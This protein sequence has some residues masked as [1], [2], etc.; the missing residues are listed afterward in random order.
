MKDSGQPQTTRSGC[1]GSRGRYSL[2]SPPPAAHIS[3]K[4]EMVGMQYGWVEIISPE[5][6]WGPTWSHCYVLTRCKGCGSVQW[7]FLENLTSGK[8]KG[9][10]E[11]SKPRQIPKWLEK[12]LSGAKQRCENP[13]I[14][15]YARYG[16]RGIEFR[17]PSVLEAGLWILENVENVRPDLELDRINTNGHYEPG[18]VRFVES[19]VNSAN[20]RISVIPFFRQDEWPYVR[21][22]VTKK[23]SN[24]MSR[25]E[26]IADAQKAVDEKRK[27]WRL[28]E[29]RLEFMTYEMRDPDTVLPYRGA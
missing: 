10:K 25:E 7:Q 6:R 11:C 2:E 29:A 24:G 9:C 14:E 12:R 27:N 8:S 5:R 28:I 20:R 3:Y 17:F 22:V 19:A 16:G 15:Q 21:G 18:N 26:I 4:P 13:R 23:L 1:K